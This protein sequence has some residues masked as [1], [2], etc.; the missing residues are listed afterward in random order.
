LAWK[1]FFSPAARLPCRRSQMA[2]TPLPKGN[3]T[4]NALK[5]Y[6]FKGSRKFRLRA[7]VKLFP[8][9]VLTIESFNFGQLSLERKT[10]EPVL[11]LLTT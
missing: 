5:I 8:G 7:A 10:D 3:M 1:K 11:K 6:D 4:K 9:L 2:I